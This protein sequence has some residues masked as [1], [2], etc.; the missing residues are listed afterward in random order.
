[1]RLIVLVLVAGFL[2][3][4][5]WSLAHS[6]PLSGAFATLEP[7][8]VDQCRRIDVAPGTEDVA[9]DPELNLAFISTAD[10]RAWYNE[11][12]DARAN[13]KTVSTRW[14]LMDRTR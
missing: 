2:A 4:L 7:K 13:P 5:A 11:T 12:E 6:I 9:I 8:L 14:R 3:G 10:R 1:M